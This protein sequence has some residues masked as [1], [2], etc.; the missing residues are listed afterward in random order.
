MEAINSDSWE[1][2]ITIRNKMHWTISITADEYR[3]IV[4]NTQTMRKWADRREHVRIT[5]NEIKQLKNKLTS[6]WP[7]KCLMTKTGTYNDLPN[8]T[9]VNI[10]EGWIQISY[11][12]KTNIWDKYDLTFSFGN[13]NYRV[14]W[15]VVRN[16]WNKHWLK[17]ID[18]D[19]DLTI[20]HFHKKLVTLIKNSLI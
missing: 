6:K 3:K 9:I 8:T 18:I 15:E 19:T 10:S 17:F 20:K 11:N 1:E 4:G 5:P 13:I 12:W 2:T 16:N 14:R 7:Y